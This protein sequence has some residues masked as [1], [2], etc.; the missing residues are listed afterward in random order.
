VPGSVANVTPGSLS[1]NFFFSLQPLATVGY[2]VMVP[3]T[4]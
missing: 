4:P 1:D 3:P 2:G